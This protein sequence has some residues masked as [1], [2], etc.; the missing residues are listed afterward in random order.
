MRRITM[1][2]VVCSLLVAGCEP[3][4]SSPKTPA[5]KPDSSGRPPAPLFP[6]P[7]TEAAT[8]KEAGSGTAKPDVVREK[9]VVGVGKKGRDYEPGLVTTP[10]AVYFRGPQMMVFNIQ[11]PSAMKMYYG[12]NGH[13]PKSHDEFMKIMA[14][15][16]IKLPDLT[17]GQ[18]Y[19][20]DAEAAAKMRSWDPADPP[21]LVEHER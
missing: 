17:P 12:V 4:P 14:E 15:N 8:G 7:A 2:V 19:I 1:T 6:I 16:Q 9:A 5:G 13:F 20:Y 18:R 10:V 3:P 21:L 11:I